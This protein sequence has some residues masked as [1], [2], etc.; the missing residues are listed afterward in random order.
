[1][2]KFKTMSYNDDWFKNPFGHM[3]LDLDGNPVR[4]TK[5]E[6]PYS[7]DAYVVWEKDYK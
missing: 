5:D 2:R 3:Y 7:Y 4:R 6:Y 1:M